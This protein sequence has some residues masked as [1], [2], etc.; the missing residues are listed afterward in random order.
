MQASRTG[1]TLV[2]SCWA[3][4]CIRS[5]CPGRKLPAISASFSATYVRNERLPRSRGSIRIC[6]LPILPGRFGCKRVAAAVAA[7]DVESLGEVI[8]SRRCLLDLGA[9][10]RRSL[11]G[12]ERT[13]NLLHHF[14]R[15]IDDRAIVTRREIQSL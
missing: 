10:A 3:R 11:S 13:Q 12:G 8:R 5:R 15:P 1:V 4:S 2:P 7:D 9:R 6:S 14:E